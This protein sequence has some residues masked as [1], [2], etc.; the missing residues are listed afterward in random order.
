MCASNYGRIANTRA[1]NPEPPLGFGKLTT[2]DCAGFGNLIE[3]CEQLD[4]VM[5]RAENVSLKRVILLRCGDAGV[6][7]G[8]FV[9]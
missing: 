6:G 2:H 9:A 4:L 8:S 3:I 7:I 5:V 1:G